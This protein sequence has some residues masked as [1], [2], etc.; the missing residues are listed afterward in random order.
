MDNLVITVS[1]VDTTD[2]VDT[3]HEQDVLDYP[4]NPNL[5]D[6][7]ARL[8]ALGMVYERNYMSFDIALCVARE[9]NGASRVILDDHADLA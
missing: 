6:E 7:T 4:V 2:G 9:G 8:V 3:W 5:D 1:R